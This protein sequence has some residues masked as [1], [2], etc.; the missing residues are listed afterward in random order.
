MTPIL[1][2][3]A[4]ETADA[5]IAPNRAIGPKIDPLT[6]TKRHEQN[7][8]GIPNPETTAIVVEVQT[9]TQIVAV[10]AEARMIKVGEKIFAID[11]TTIQHD[12]V[13]AIHLRRDDVTPAP[14]T[15]IATHDPSTGKIVK[16]LEASEHQC[17][18]DRSGDAIE[19]L[20]GKPNHR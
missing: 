15:K 3:L 13:G 20:S 18:A 8:A 12:R 4:A 6:D 10:E 19:N 7:H 5:R 1:K 17:A 11:V 2:T 14:E 9:T 16:N